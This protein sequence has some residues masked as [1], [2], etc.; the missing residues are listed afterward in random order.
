MSTSVNM[1]MT[2]AM[3]WR[4]E[5]SLGSVA[6][7]NPSYNQCLFWESQS[8]G[9]PVGGW[10]LGWRSPGLPPAP[11]SLRMGSPPIPLLSPWK[12]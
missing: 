12:V 5:M 6:R 11:D 4:G 1:S 2:T 7:D 9:L 8:K 10:N 3:T